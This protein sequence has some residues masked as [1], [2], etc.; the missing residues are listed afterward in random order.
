M[1]CLVK[2]VK[3]L[4]DKCPLKF[5]V[6]RQIACLDPARMN[7]DSKNLVQTFIQG[8]QLALQLVRKYCI[9]TVEVDRLFKL[10][11][12]L[13]LESHLRFLP[14]YSERCESVLFLPN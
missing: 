10:I 13:C 14:F 1:Q 3:K 12:V 7:R 8:K 9:G 6:V 11:R 4:Q 2:I 5:P